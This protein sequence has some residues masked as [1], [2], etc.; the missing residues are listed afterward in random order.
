[1]SDGGKCGAEASAPGG[2]EIRVTETKAVTQ[3]CQRKRP[4]AR[5]EQAVRGGRRLKVPGPHLYRRAPT[6]S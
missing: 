1:M 2:P 3:S 4:Q 6:F 5:R